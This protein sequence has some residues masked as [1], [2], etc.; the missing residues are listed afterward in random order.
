MTYCPLLTEA[1]MRS[2][3]VQRPNLCPVPAFVIEV[4]VA[5]GSTAAA[6]NPSTDTSADAWFSG[7]KAFVKGHTH[8]DSAEFAAENFC[9][10]MVTGLAS[11]GQLL[12][13]NM[14]F[15]PPW[16]STAREL[17]RVVVQYIEAQPERMHEDFRT[18]T[19]QAFHKAW[20]GP[21]KPGR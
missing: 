5:L 13:S 3:T 1:D 9:S 17:A 10:G 18:L 14:Q 7:C 16:N 6:Q 19:L 12:P 21:C 11:V 8:T 4:L 2:I 15:C 20:P